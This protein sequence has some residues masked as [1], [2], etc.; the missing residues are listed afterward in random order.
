MFIWEAQ[1]N[2]NEYRAM[3]LKPKGKLSDHFDE[4]E[5]PGIERRKRHK[6]I[7][8]LR[9]AILAVICGADSWLD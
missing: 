5:D 8:I 2:P 3:K 9:I 4:I 6:L 7:D 1:L